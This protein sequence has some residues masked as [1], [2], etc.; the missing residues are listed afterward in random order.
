MLETIGL[1]TSLLSIPFRSVTLRDEGGENFT[2]FSRPLGV[3]APPPCRKIKK[4][5]GW[6]LEKFM[7]DE[8]S[9]EFSGFG[10]FDERAGGGRENQL[11]G[12]GHWNGGAGGSRAR[13]RGRG[14][15]GGGGRGRGRGGGGSQGRGGGGGMNGISGSHDLEK[16]VEQLESTV[17]DLQV[18][19]SKRCL[20]LSGADVRRQQGEVPFMT[21]RR[22]VWTNWEVQVP[23]VDVAVSHWLQGGK[24]L[25]AEF[26]QRDA[27][28][29]FDYIMSNPRGLGKL[30]IFA[31]LRLTT[32]QKRLKFLANLMM[33][34]GDI[35]SF[36]ICHISG[37]L[38]IMTRQGILRSIC[39]PGQ[40]F[41]LMS[42]EVKAKA[43]N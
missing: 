7:M 16:R 3:E 35:M 41:P 31:S 19:V 30:R 26:L 23:R 8:K 21:L 34:G 36:H 27:G 2:A 39:E 9:G 1:I 15:G 42:E 43:K 13:G 32:R 29:T 10:Y 37:K 38:R 20:I 14:R 17:A 28:S 40:L 6:D 12:F 11:T 33:E 5:P 18:M 22:L 4:L 25:I 24:S